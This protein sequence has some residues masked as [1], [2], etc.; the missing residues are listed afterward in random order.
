MVD[1]APR[2]YDIVILAGYGNDAVANFLVSQF[3]NMARHSAKDALVTIARGIVQEIFR[4]KLT[5]AE[6]EAYERRPLGLESSIKPLIGCAVFLLVVAFIAMSPFFVKDDF[7]TTVGF[8]S[9]F[10]CVT[11]MTAT[12]C[13]TQPYVF[14]DSWL[15]DL[16]KSMIKQLG[17]DVFL[18]GLIHRLNEDF[19]PNGWIT[20]AVV[21]GK[22][23]EKEALRLRSEFPKKRIV[24]IE[25]KHASQPWD[26]IH[27][28][29]A[30][31]CKKA[32]ISVYNLHARDN[33]AELRAQL[34]DLMRST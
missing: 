31:D 13:L 23:Y 3:P 2:A 30:R 1:P 10:V 25:I 34:L 6:F 21:I 8:L 7:G 9:T 18:N 29:T 32:G 15:R 27:E 28:Y 20:G 33:P 4:I 19:A 24:M 22:D 14:V 11:L 12:A 26:N 17:S 5:R 16:E